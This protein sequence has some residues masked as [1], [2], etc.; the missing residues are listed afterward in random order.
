MMQELYNGMEQNFWYI[1]MFI[2]NI[3]QKDPMQGVWKRGW[4]LLLMPQTSLL[5][6]ADCNKPS[7]EDGRE[8]L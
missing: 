3:M 8:V 6:V 2:Y 1:R 5:L 4:I 7:L